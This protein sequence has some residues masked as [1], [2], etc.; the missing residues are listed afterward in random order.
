MAAVP[1]A[2]RIDKT[3]KRRENKNN[4]RGEKTKS[5]A[6]SGQIRDSPQTHGSSPRQGAVI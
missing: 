3:Q 4:S 2:P 1:I 6:A 5:T